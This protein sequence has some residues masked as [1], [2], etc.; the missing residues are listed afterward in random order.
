MKALTLT[1]ILISTL[2]LS[3]FPTYLYADDYYI[4]PI[5]GD[6]SNPGTSKAPWKKIAKANSVLNSGDTVHLMAGTYDETIRPAKSGSSGKYITYAA[7]NDDVVT[8]GGQ[9]K[10]GADLSD[11]SWIKINGLRFSDTSYFWIQFYPNGSHNYIT[12]CQFKSTGASMN[13]AGVYIKGRADYNKIINNSFVSA[14][15]PSDLIDIRASSYNLIEGNYFGIT[16]HTALALSGKDGKTEYNIIRN[17]TLQNKYHHNLEVYHNADYTLV[18]G[19]KI[20]DAGDACDSDSC[21]ANTCGSDRD[22]NTFR[23]RDYN[24]M[25]LMSKYCIVRNNLFV[26]NGTF[27]M[28]SY[29]LGSGEYAIGNR[30]YNNTSYGNYRAML[31]NPPSDGPVSNNIIKN[32][33]YSNS[34]VDSLYFN[35]KVVDT[36]NRFLTNNYF[37]T[38]VIFKYVS[39]VSNVES[40]YSSEWNGNSSLTDINPGFINTN[41]RNFCLRG[42][43]KIIDKGTW[44]TV[45]TSPSGSGISFTVNDARYFSDGFG[46]I[47]ADKIQ[48]QNQSFSVRIKSIDYTSNRI[49]LESSVS[50][51]KGDGISLPYSGDKPDIGA[52]EYGL[53]QANAES[54][55]S[56]PSLSI[57]K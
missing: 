48:I 12:N 42:D 8:I 16:N 41:A 31:V 39:G 2:V 7:Y 34:H 50:W 52:F 13:W 46:L 4:N 38:P 33:I 21:H 3:L 45:I 28:Y 37:N 24:S 47:P 51:N 18:E 43:S 15:L 57:K 9:I 35:P 54:S 25:K 44:L 30:I 29:G 6:D 1:L 32:N 27:D 11:R 40:E 20:L 14:C 23:R 55:L 26:N 19:N 49:E 56:A 22:R 17:N 53:I 36:S 10:Y 5:F